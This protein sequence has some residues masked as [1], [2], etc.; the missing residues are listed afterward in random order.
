M[1]EVR[2]ISEL[3]DEQLENMVGWLVGRSHV[4]VS[5]KGIR[6]TVGRKLNKSIQGEDR[7][8]VLDAAVRVHQ[9]NRDFFKRMRF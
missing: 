2:E 1:A 7:K 9:A 4:S 8:R 6:S 3:T 5:D